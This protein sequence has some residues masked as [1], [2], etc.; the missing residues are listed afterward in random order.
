MAIR[1]AAPSFDGAARHE[2]GSLNSH[3]Q[4]ALESLHARIRVLERGSGTQG[5][6]S[7]KQQKLAVVPPRAGLAVMPSPVAGQIAVAITN[8]EFGAVKGKNPLRAAIY[9]RI[10]YS[11]DPSFR[12]GV[13]KLPYSPQTHWPLTVAP[14]RTL[15][16]HL[17]S[18]HDGRNWSLPVLSGPV[19]V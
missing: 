8:P 16:F 15:H 10:Q 7:D 6:D 18:S 13:T 1:E 2:S 12:T 17:Q 19:K 14:G 3:L 5:L 11:E 4:K 9:H